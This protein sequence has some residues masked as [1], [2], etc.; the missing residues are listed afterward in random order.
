MWKQIFKMGDCLKHLMV[1]SSFAFRENG[2]QD[3]GYALPIG[4]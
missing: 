3:D 1:L 4:S 2:S